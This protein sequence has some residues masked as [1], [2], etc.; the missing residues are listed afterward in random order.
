MNASQVQLNYKENAIRACADALRQAILDDWLDSGTLVPVPPS[1]SPTDALYDNRI[2]RVCQLIRPGN[3][4]V[5]NLVVQGKSMTA[6]HERPPGNR[7]TIAEL[8]ASYSIDEDLAEPTPTSIAVVDD[9]LTA[10]THYRAMQTI[11]AQRFP[12]AHIFGMFIA[13]RIFPDEADF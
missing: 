13:R 5:R 12:Q 1:K 3:I 10:G 4:D 11:L 9:M 2:E 6:S 7:I 8:V